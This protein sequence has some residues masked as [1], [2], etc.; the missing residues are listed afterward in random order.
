MDIE[1][2]HENNKT[3][4]NITGRI[5]GQ[6][7]PDLQDSINESL[8][9]G[10]KNLEFDFKNVEYISSAGL[11]T[12]LYAQKRI[13]NIEGANM[14]IK[15]ANDVVMEVFEMTGFTDFLTIL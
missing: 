14:C 11:R 9:A 15:N 10:E 4:F 7:S 8:D 12:M 1:K 2:L 3:I 6:T 5:D 13:N